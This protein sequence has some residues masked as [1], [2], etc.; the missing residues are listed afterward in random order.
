MIHVQCDDIPHEPIAWPD[1]HIGEFLANDEKSVISPGIGNF[2]RGFEHP[3]CNFLK[4]DCPIPDL[5]LS[6]Y[7]VTEPQIPTITISTQWL[8]ITFWESISLDESIRCGFRGSADILRTLHH[9]NSDSLAC[10]RR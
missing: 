5:H 1:S 3:A 6:N 8:P 2:G 10:V 7:A 9:I 4:A